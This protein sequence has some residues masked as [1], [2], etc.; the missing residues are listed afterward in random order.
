MKNIVICS[1]LVFLQSFAHAS[2]GDTNNWGMFRPNESLGYFAN[3]PKANSDLPNYTLQNTPIKLSA[4]AT[5]S[6]DPAA[7]PPSLSGISS[8]L[9]QSVGIICA[10][11][12][13][14]LVYGFTT[15]ALQ[16]A[17]PSLRF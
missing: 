17:L 15:V 7:T 11:Y 5:N 14:Y 4:T 8:K 9:S 2:S 16:W 13:G 12:T 6:S 10:I 1:A 3:N